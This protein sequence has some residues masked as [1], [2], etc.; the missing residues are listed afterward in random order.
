MTNPNNDDRSK[1]DN[2]GNSDRDG[3]RDGQ[4]PA[5]KPQP[6]SIPDPN[7]GAGEDGRNPGVGHDDENKSDRDRGDGRRGGDQVGV[8]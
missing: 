8:G 5:G 3:N 4:T 2:R 6:G 1:G 7:R